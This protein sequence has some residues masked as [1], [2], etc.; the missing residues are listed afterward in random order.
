MDECNIGGKTGAE[1]TKSKGLFFADVDVDLKL[2]DGKTAFPGASELVEKLVPVS[3]FI[4]GRDSAPRMH[5]GFLV[6]AVGPTVQYHGVDSKMLIEL[7]MMTHGTKRGK[8]PERLDAAT[9]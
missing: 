1:L 5:F 6:N 4:F 9:A 8:P 2:A 7:Q 3:G